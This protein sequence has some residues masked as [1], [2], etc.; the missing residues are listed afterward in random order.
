MTIVNNSGKQK[1]IWSS[2][3]SGSKSGS[4]SGYKSGFGS[5]LGSNN[6]PVSRSYSTNLS[7]KPSNLEKVQPTIPAPKPTNTQQPEPSYQVPP[8]TWGNRDSM[9]GRIMDNVLTGVTVGT[10]S[11]I[12]HRVI[13]SIGSNQPTS[14]NTLNST[15]ITNTTNSIS[16]SEIKEFYAKLKNNF[17][18]NPELNK[19]FINFCTK[20]NCNLD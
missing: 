8:M 18:S 20:F 1:G 10:G 6:S 11:A 3:G 16:C 5:G 4:W 9:G 14:S 2:S 19:D 15:N 13:G 7:D 17:E 12:A